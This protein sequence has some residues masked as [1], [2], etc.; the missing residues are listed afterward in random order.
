[1]E[2]KILLFS[3][4]PAN[5]EQE[6]L[7]NLKIFRQTRICNKV[8]DIVKN[9]NK[10]IYLLLVSPKDKI[11]IFTL[12]QFLPKEKLPQIINISDLKDLKC[13]YYSKVTPL[14]NS[15][16]CL[17]LFLNKTGIYHT[18]SVHN[19]LKY[20]LYVMATFNINH[21]SYKL[22][23]LVCCMLGQEYNHTISMLR[24]Y[25][26]TVIVNKRSPFLKNLFTNNSNKK[27]Y[28][29]NAINYCYQKFYYNQ[30]VF[31]TFKKMPFFN[32]NYYLERLKMEKI[33]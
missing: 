28:I 18:T 16:N 3:T 10:N 27:V 15:L 7:T 21:F 29:L 22:L 6:N 23:H 14:K 25:L 12:E 2:Q 24:N 20:C 11:S 5:L 13:K 9:I 33:K 17:E 30:R 1:M 8:E 32:K 31:Y 4:C 26:H 19:I